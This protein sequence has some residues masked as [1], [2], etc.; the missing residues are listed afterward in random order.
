MGKLKKLNLFNK[1]SKKMKYP[2]KVKVAETSFTNEITGY[3]FTKNVDQ[4][5]TFYTSKKGY[6]YLN[7]QKLI[8]ETDYLAKKNQFKILLSRKWLSI[9][10]LCIIFMILLLGKNYIR[11]IEFANNT[12]YSKDVLDVVMENL[13]D[14]KMYYTLKG[15][16]NDISKKLRSRFPYYEWIGLRKD[17]NV[18]YID[19]VDLEPLLITKK[20][21]TYGDLIASKTAYIINFHIVSG[22]LVVNSNMTVRK[23]ELLVS[24]DLNYLDSKTKANMTSPNGYVNGETF[25]IINVSINKKEEKI[26]YTGNI[27][28]KKRIVFKSRYTKSKTSFENAYYQKEVLFKFGPFYYIK[29]SYFERELVKKEYDINDAISLAKMNIEADF[30]HISRNEYEKILKMEVI[31]TTMEEDNYLIT[32]IVSKIENIAIFKPISTS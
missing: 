32:M 10:S 15:S 17:G 6:D 24:G 14:K 27:Q 9:T 30:Y 18:L 20:N 22:L 5:I 8:I 16:L 12:Y 21:D 4:T 19:I 29:E 7:N 2:Y 28:T 11:R 3:W 13:N 26:V 25:E 31:K 1:I 23:G